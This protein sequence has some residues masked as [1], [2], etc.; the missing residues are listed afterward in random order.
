[1]HP[2]KTRLLPIFLP[3]RERLHQDGS[4]IAVPFI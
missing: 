3:P 1:M 4:W 2:G